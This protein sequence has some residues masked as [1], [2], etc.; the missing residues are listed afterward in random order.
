MSESY[1][2]GIE[3][4]DLIYDA[5]CWDLLLCIVTVLCFFLLGI[6]SVWLLVVGFFFWIPQLRDFEF[7]FFKE[8]LDF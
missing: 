1:K 5:Q 8:T 7:F 4:Q 2:Q 3:L 6:R